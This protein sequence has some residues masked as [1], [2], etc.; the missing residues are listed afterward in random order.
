MRA[1]VLAVL[2]AGCLAPVPAG[3][4]P[5]AASPATYAWGLA[6]CAYVI[7]IVPVDAGA[8]AAVL[9]E[10]FTPLPGRVAL[11]G[12]DAELHL[13]AYRC[14][15]GVDLDGGALADVAYASAY[16]PVEPP[17]EL[18]ED[19][20]D[21]YF[22]KLDF[23]VPDA[24]RRT[25]LAAAG[26]PARAGSAEVALAP[27]RASAAVALEGAGAWTFEGVAGPE[28]GQDA[29]LPF[30]EHTPVADGRGLAR[31]HARLHDAT[32]AS[33]AGVVT[34]EGASWMRDVAGADRVPA[35]FLAGAWNLDEADVAFPIAWP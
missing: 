34:F 28:D 11:P 8:L 15:E 10:G 2:L 29:P 24:P 30:V 4:A 13:E 22:V 27:A 32:F 12:R 20:Y 3:G 5:P 33:G 19:G 18:R 16:V 1:A 6:D 23:L 31:W 25:T 7:A 9:P 17:P 35:A 14:A 21:A 26:L